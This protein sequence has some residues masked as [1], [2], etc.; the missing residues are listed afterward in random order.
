MDM[1]YEM[2]ISTM[3]FL[4]R[5]SHNKPDRVDAQFKLY[6]WIGRQVNAFLEEENLLQDCSEEKKEILRI[7]IL[8]VINEGC[9]GVNQHYW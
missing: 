5:P 9:K 2:Q 1:D 7:N 3:C 8:R 6:E 4:F